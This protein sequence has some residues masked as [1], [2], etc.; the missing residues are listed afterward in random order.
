MSLVYETSVLPLNYSAIE[1]WWIE[2]DS[3]VR[4]PEG[5]VGL[6][7]T[8][9]AAIRSIQKMEARVGIEPTLVILQITDF[10][11]VERAIKNSGHPC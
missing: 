3:N 10:P 5:T 4:S 6:Q 7:P 2:H 8:V 1:T 11:L 9:I